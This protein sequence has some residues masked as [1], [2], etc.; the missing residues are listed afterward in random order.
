MELSLLKIYK[1][2]KENAARSFWTLSALDSCCHYEPTPTVKIQ[3]TDLELRE[4]R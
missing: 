2:P 4:E 1:I 3:N